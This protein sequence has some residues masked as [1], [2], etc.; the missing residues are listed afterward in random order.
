MS[1]IDRDVISIAERR[2]AD[3]DPLGAVRLLADEAKGGERPS[4]DVALLL[5]RC[6]A[7]LNEVTKSSYWIASAIDADDDPVIW[8]AAARL[9]RRI[10]GLPTVP[11]RRTE[12]VAVV[13]SW[14]TDHLVEMMWL[15]AAR[16]GVHLEI[17]QGDLGQYRREV[18]DRSSWLYSFRPS[19]VV[20][21][22]HEG[23][24]A[25][26]AESADPDAELESEVGVWSSVWNAIRLGVGARIVHHGFAIRP[27]SPLGNLAFTLRQSRQSLLGELNRRLATAIGDEGIV[28]DC[29]GLSANIGKAQWFDDREWSLSRQ[30]VAVKCMPTL[31]RHTTAAALA[32][33][34]LSRK[35]LVLDLDGTLWGGVVAEDGLDGIAV[36]A[37]HPQGEAFQAF[38]RYLL[39]LK[40]RGILLAVAS[41]NDEE[42]AMDVFSSHRG[43]VLTRDDFAAF[44]ASWDP[45]PVQ[46]RRVAE[47][48]GVGSDS[49]VFIDDNPAERVAVR[50][51]LPEID[52]IDLPTGPHDYVKTLAAYPFLAA[53]TITDE[54]R[55]R[56]QSYHVRAAA[57]AASHQEAESMEQ[58][59]AGLEMVADVRRFA[60]PDIPRIAQLVNRSNQFNV[61]TR[62]R[63]AAELTKLIDL[64]E[65]VCLSFRLRDRLADHGLVAVVIGKH[66][67]GPQPELEIDTWLMS[68]RVIGR[69][70]EGFVLNSLIEAA[71]TAGLAGI[72]GRYIPS[73]RNGIVADLFARLGFCERDD[74]SWFLRLDSLLD[75][76]ETGAT[77]V[78][79]HIGGTR[80]QGT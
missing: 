61:T 72:S 53:V 23:E 14:T 21:A 74:G 8:Q 36:T 65:F 19:T 63:S 22:V 4:A 16:Q 25:F 2:Y 27:E 62:R 66:V 41:K 28:V 43:M 68:C 3:G 13:G 7:D 1:P 60:A 12:R 70:L 6:H 55:R 73:G 45:K 10:G 75:V 42:L 67:G 52:V 38:Q 32:L 26:A 59:L 44:V 9:A 49:L 76:S 64:P 56:T 11:I 37:D 18:H 79:T 40:R 54:D 51:S 58:F 77:E 15:A 33:M 24:V 71:K 48:L 47:M 29:E 35:C 50:E 78:A 80:S 30:A 46:L 31:A 34:G 5:A 17:R 20:V 57:H 39:E 69:T